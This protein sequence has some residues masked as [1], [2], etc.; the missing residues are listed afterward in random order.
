MA[1][2]GDLTKTCHQCHLLALVAGP[3]QHAVQTGARG[4]VTEGTQQ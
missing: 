4:Q 2:T 3:R 1:M